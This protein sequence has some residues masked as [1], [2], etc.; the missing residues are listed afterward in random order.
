MNIKGEQPSKHP[1][2][3]WESGEKTPTHIKYC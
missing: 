1:T 3:K 2:K